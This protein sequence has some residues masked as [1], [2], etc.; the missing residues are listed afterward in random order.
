M[1]YLTMLKVDNTIYSGILRQ[2]CTNP[3]SVTHATQ[4][5]TMTTNIF[6]SSA[7]NFFMTPFC[8]L[9]FLHES[10][11]FGKFVHL[12]IKVTGMWKEVVVA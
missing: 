3:G 8:C 6:G 1:I 7:W 2:G 11:I 4:F 9:E 12:C 5:C 10:K